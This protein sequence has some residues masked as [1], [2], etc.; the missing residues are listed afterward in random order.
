MVN[1]LTTVK[2]KFMN[3]KCVFMPSDA[4]IRVVLNALCHYSVNEAG[5]MDPILEVLYQAGFHF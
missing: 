3:N 5:H 2:M 4:V 1:N